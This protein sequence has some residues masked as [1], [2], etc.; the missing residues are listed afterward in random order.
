MRRIL[1]PWMFLVAVQAFAADRDDWPNVGND[2]GGMR[3]SHLAQ[4]DR[5][6][7]SKLRMAWEYHTR[8]ATE[9]TTIECTPVVGDG[10]IYVTTVRTKV[11]ALDAATGAERWS[12]DPYAGPAPRG[13]WHRASGGLTRGVS[14]GSD[15]AAARRVLVGLSD[16]RLLSLDAKT[17][18][19][20]P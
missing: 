14:Y 1:V 18:K 12:S 3:F 19:P 4:I 6:N 8:D 5:S 20:D 17:G 7:V 11:V 2:K 15:G 16:G 10:G 9:G 13:G